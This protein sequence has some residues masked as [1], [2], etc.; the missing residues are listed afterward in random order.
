MRENNV[1]AFTSIEDVA[2]SVVPGL[3]LIGYGAATKCHSMGGNANKA[4]SGLRSH[5]GKSEATLN[6]TSDLKRK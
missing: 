2:D 3:F 4:A 1:L 5:G 6:R